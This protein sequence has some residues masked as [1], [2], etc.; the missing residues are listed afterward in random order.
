M[1][2]GEIV[3]SLQ[4]GL[5]EA[6][7]NSIA[8]YDKTGKEQEAPHYTLTRHSLGMSLMVAR[9]AWWDELSMVE[10]KVIAEAW[11]KV[12]IAREQLRAEAKEDLANAE[13]MG[14]IVHALTSEQR[15]LW[16]QASQGQ[17]ERMAET[18]GGRSQDLLNLIKQGKTE[19]QTQFSE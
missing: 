1:G 12:S 19:Y 18:I 14:I 8:L 2:Y 5:I 15:A 7:D 3:Q 13:K 6:G 16:R 4:T 17:T 11:P 10:Q 9:K